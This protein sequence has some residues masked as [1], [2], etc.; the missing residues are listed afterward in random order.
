VEQNIEAILEIR[1]GLTAAE[2]RDRLQELME[3]LGISHLAGQLGVSL[4]G[5]ERRRAE[6]ARALAAGPRFILLDEPFAGVDPISVIEIQKIVE[7]L[8]DLDI[9]VLITD[10]NV[11]ETLGICDH[12]YILN[13][14]RVLAEGRP[15]SIV[16]NDE[17]REVYLGKNFR[18]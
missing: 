7:H 4:S 8:T 9:G 5:G 2:R 18:L 1:K 14:G 17:V 10:H 6:I 3:D 11:R 15:E 16:E 12:A 13:E